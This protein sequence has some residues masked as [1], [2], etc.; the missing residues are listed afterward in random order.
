MVPEYLST[1]FLALLTF[2]RKSLT[3]NFKCNESTFKINTLGLYIWHVLVTNCFIMVTIK[4]FHRNMSFN[5]PLYSNSS[6]SVA[7]SLIDK[8]SRESKK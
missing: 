8:S 1:I 6:K 2:T 3:T 4:C 7:T 5:S